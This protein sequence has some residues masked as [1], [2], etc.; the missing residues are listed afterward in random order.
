MSDLTRR[1]EPGRRP[2]EPPGGDI[3]GLLDD[4]HRTLPAPELA[5]LLLGVERAAAPLTRGHAPD[6]PSA[7]APGAGV[8]VQGYLARMVA[9]RRAWAAS[10]SEGDSGPARVRLGLWLRDELDDV[11]SRP[12]G[13]AVPAA[14]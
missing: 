9:V 11:A 7:V 1:Y 4:A 12:R 14:A 6:E 5:E 2:P 13:A 8:E 10:D 3:A